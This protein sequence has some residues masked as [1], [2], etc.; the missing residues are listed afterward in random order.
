M[1]RSA[2]LQSAMFSPQ[3]GEICRGPDLRRR[4]IL[5]I[6]SGSD[7]SEKKSA[8]AKQVPASFSSGESVAPQIGDLTNTPDRLDAW[9]NAEPALPAKSATIPRAV[10]RSESPSQRGWFE[11][12]A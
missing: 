11:R 4:Q 2:E 10:Y 3:N 5:I 9:S 8:Q 6:A 7:G 12:S 1:S